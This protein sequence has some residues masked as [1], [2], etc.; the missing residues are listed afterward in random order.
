[1]KFYKF[2]H[3]EKETYR[4][5]KENLDSSINSYK[6][7]LA[8]NDKV[9]KNLAKIKTDKE[10]DRENTERINSEIELLAVRKEEIGAEVSELQEKLSQKNIDLNDID[11]KIVNLFNLEKL[12]L[13][14]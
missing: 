11:E 2:K 14:K 13:T 3:D 1:M 9:T 10:N 7:A 8:K 5:Y 12:R 4:I 6:D